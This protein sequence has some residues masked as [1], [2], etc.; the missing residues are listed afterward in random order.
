MLF[1]SSHFKDLSICRS[2][3]IGCHVLHSGY[4]GFLAFILVIYSEASALVKPVCHTLKLQEH[5]VV[6]QNLKKI[7]AYFQKLTTFIYSS[8]S[9]EACVLLRL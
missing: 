9:L 7:C 6:F 8:A 3:N 5:G 1:S 4:F 2:T